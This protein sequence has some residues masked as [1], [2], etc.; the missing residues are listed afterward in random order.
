MCIWLVFI[1]YYYSYELFSFL[2]FSFAGHHY[3]QLW[4]SN[5]D[6]RQHDI[7]SMRT[8]LLQQV[9]LHEC[10]TVRSHRVFSGENA[11]CQ[12]ELLESCETQQDFPPVC[13]QKY[14]LPA[15]CVSFFQSA[16][17]SRYILYRYNHYVSVSY[18]K[19]SIWK[20]PSEYQANTFTAACS[21]PLL[22]TSI[23]RSDIAIPGSNPTWA[24]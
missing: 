2:L 8:F 15:W 3:Q 1:Q 18:L 20:F 22:P 21:G 12:K 4:Q 23:V 19:F 6:N 7:D 11:A 9:T 5:G 13:H 16:K 10:T 17:S 14:F 24:W